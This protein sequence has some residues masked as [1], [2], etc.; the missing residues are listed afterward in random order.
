MKYSINVSFPKANS[1]PI[2][3]HYKITKEGNLKTITCKVASSESIPGWLEL[4]KFE[5]VGL[6]SEDS[7]D[8]LFQIKKYEK[9]LDTVLFMDK[10]FERIINTQDR[11]TI[12]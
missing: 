9:N 12:Q 4:T 11:A 1:T 10:V 6:K 2:N 7:Y 5:L 3:V 8:L